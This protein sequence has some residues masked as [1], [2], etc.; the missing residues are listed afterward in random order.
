MGTHVR[1]YKWYVPQHQ[2][3]ETPARLRLSYIVVWLLGVFH[4]QTDALTRQARS[5]RAGISRLLP[6]PRG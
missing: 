4:H 2:T 1:E 5:M 6:N 3:L